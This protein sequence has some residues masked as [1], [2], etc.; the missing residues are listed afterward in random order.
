VCPAVWVDLFKTRAFGFLAH[1]QVPKD[2]WSCSAKSTDIGWLVIVFNLLREIVLRCSQWAKMRRLYGSSGSSPQPALKTVVFLIDEAP[3]DFLGL[4]LLGMHLLSQGFRVVISERP[5]GLLW[6][7]FPGAVFVG[8]AGLRKVDSFQGS[9][10]LHPAEGAHFQEF[11]WRETVL[12]KYFVAAMAR[13]RPEKV[14]VWGTEQE[15]ILHDF[16][17]G[18]RGVTVVT[19]AQRLDLC[20]KKNHWLSDRQSTKLRAELG[21]FTLI[22]TRFSTVLHV[23]PLRSLTSLLTRADRPLAAE[24]QANRWSQDSVDFGMF[25]V[26]I[27]R[28]LTE[29]PDRHFVIRP[30]PSEN[31][32]IY[33]KLFGHFSNLTT[34][35][36]GNLLPWLL[37]SKLLVTSNSTSGV[38][39]ALAGIPTVNLSSSVLPPTGQNISVASE[40]GAVVHSVEEALAACRLALEGPPRSARQEWSDVARKRL[41]NLSR[42]DATTLIAESVAAMAAGKPPAKKPSLKQ[43]GTLRLR[44]EILAL[45]HSHPLGETIG[46]STAEVRRLFEEAPDHGFSQSRMVFSSYGTYVMEPV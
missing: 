8:K 30:H 14:F 34:T 9:F 33:Q 11:N 7:V 16:D 38:E 44:N 22:A 12:D 42:D 20:L 10:A 43:L 3:R 13:I 5:L 21:D 31:M 37:A 39:A 29:F 32:A 35:R 46:L 28:L 24:I 27:R 17:S 26:L 36:D 15:E 23:E 25:I 40:A 4:A 45:A 6:R 41:A 18:Y 2:K 19:G 1:P